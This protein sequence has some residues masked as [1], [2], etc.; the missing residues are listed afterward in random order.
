[1]AI[2]SEHNI[3]LMTDS[4]KVPHYNFYPPGT[5]H[6]YSYFESRGGKYDKLVFFGLQYFLKK[7]LE[8]E[9]VNI[10]KIEEADFLLK[11]HFGG[12]PLLNK[13]GWLHVVH[14]H[15]G[16]L[17]VCIKAVREGSVKNAF[18][19]L[20]SVENT[21][22]ACFWLTNYLETLLVQVWY[23]TTVATQSWHM[24]KIIE[25][26]L[27][28][29]GDPSTISFRLHDFGFR[30]VSSPESAGI[31]GLAHLVNF[32]GTDTLESLAVARNFYYDECAGFSIP[33]TE[34]SNITAWGASH[35]CE[36]F[37]N[38]LE[39][40]PEGLVACV[41]DSYDIY[42]ACAEY[43]GGKLRHK[44]S[45]RNGT[46]VI[47]PDS[48][49]PTEVL[50]RIL[51]IL[52]QK[53]GYTKNEKGFKV[54]P[55]CVRL[56]QGDGITADSIKGILDSIIGAGWSTDNLSFGSG[57][58]LLQ[59]VDRDTL[60]FA[61]K[62]SYAVVN[63]EGRPVYKQPITDGGKAS[64]SGRFESHGL[65]EVFRD[66]KVNRTFTLEEVRSTLWKSPAI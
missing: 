49:E 40:H 63:G 24:K 9:V 54:L 5:Q 26:A 15:N 41:S 32:F 44:I 29:T 31:G 37:D 36:A 52:G 65:E 60:K 27:E 2:S 47:R 16:H 48:G 66:G 50:P 17:P 59:K 53:F 1:M 51:E 21:D 10:E 25:E 7:Y 20:I 12:K 55:D 46:L 19:P 58:G 13:E 45:S 43:W 62:C 61:F 35:E 3:V 18:E 64:K 38:L 39:Q 34:H 14:K 28:K 30:G 22:P 42:R 6:I 11:K 23:P 57:G 8:G 33:A 56:I 4:Y